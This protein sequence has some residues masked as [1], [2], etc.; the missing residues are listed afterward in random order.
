MQH[1]IFLLGKPWNEDC[2]QFSKEFLKTGEILREMGS[3]V[4]LGLVDASEEG[5]LDLMYAGDHYPVI[6]LFVG[7]EIHEYHGT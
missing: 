3:S 1:I 5:E 7:K 2:K 4:T 6:K